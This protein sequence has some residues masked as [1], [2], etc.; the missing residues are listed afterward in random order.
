MVTMETGHFL[1]T[2]NDASLASLVFLMRK[3]LGCIICKTPRER[4]ASLHL[5]SL[6]IFISSDYN[7][8]A[9]MVASMHSLRWRSFAVSVKSPSRNLVYHQI[10]WALFFFEVAQVHPRRYLPHCWSPLSS[11]DLGIIAHR[12]VFV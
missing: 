12:P 10:R 2:L 3:V 6:T 1:K 8:H 5:L 4:Y 9:T 7:V 11:V